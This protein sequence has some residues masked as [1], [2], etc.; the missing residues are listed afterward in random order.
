MP[1]E[2][3]VTSATFPFRLLFISQRYGKSPALAKFLEVLKPRSPHRP[4]VAAD[5]Q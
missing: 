3:P 2:A 1:R 5:E 4:G